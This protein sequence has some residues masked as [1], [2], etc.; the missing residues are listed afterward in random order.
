MKN[1]DKDI[2]CQHRREF[3]VKTT[4]TAGA[5][6]LS[7]A[8]LT[9]AQAPVN[10]PDEVTLKLDSKSPLNR[11]G[12]TQTFDYKGDKVVVLR[13]SETDFVAYSAICPHRGGLV[14]YHEKTQQFVCPLHNSRFAGDG[15]NVSG[16]ARQ[17][18]SSF[19]TQSA[20]VVSLKL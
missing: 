7:L 12:G 16:P 4:A 15:Q 20:V 6:V 18:L 19:P 14:A 8:G 2:I 17:P 1:Y 13:Q 9:P 5:L 11:V 3:L 10:D